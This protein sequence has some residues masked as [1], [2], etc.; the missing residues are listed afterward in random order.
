MKLDAFLVPVLKN[1][2]SWISELVELCHA[3]DHQPLSNEV[4]RIKLKYI[5]DLKPNLRQLSLFEAYAEPE[6]NFVY[7]KAIRL[8]P[9]PSLPAEFDKKIKYIFNSV[10]EKCQE[11][12][13]VKTQNILEKQAVSLFADSIADK[14]F[15]QITYKIKEVM[16]AH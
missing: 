5:S 7:T 16:K 3:V 13:L 9:K 12:D 10:K 11:R 2:Q 4:A 1:Y 6:S 8:V 15:D 14:S